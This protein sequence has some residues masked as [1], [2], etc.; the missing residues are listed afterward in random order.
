MVMAFA[1]VWLVYLG[2]K[3]WLKNKRM[4]DHNEMRE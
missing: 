2:K 4:S 1:T 3:I